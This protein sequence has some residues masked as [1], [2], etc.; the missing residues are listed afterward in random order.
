MQSI[1]PLG[2]VPDWITGIKDEV[3]KRKAAEA[4]V[5]GLPQEAAAADQ[6]AES[7]KA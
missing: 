7:S 1:A 4:A 6:P 2:V 3:E 5:A